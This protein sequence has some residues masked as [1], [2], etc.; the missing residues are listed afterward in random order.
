MISEKDSLTVIIPAFNEEKNLRQTVDGLIPHVSKEFPE[1]EIIIFNDDSSD[2]TGEIADD[3]KKK[4]PQIVRVV[5]NSENRGLGYNY[6]SGLK[7]AQKKYVIMCPGDN[8]N[9]PESIIEI[10]RFRG[11]AD[12]VIPY[13]SNLE[14]RTLRRRLISKTY[15]ALMNFLAAQKVRYYNGT[16]LHTTRVVQPMN[17]ESDG[18][19]YQSEILVRLLKSGHSFIEIPF[20]LG[21]SG[22]GKSA[23]F[24]W[25]NIVSVAKTVLTIAIESNKISAH[26]RKELL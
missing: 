12:I 26:A 9:S 2:K 6:K 7:L 15:V 19:G 20:L 25:K 22:R 4:Y 8:E 14:V 24:R 21:V 5:H 3:L 17:I 18:F 10:C 16:V 1:Y 23:A 11:K 13:P